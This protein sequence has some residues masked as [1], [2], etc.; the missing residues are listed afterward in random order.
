[1][2][3]MTCLQLGGKCDQKLSADTWDQMVQAITKHVTEKHPGVAKEMEQMHRDDP[4]KWA[5][6]TKPRWDATADD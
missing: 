1:M 3:T 2:K 5:A 6:E 4:K